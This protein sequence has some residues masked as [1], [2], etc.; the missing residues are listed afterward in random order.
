MF[1]VEIVK[2]RSRNFNFIIF[3]LNRD[4]SH[5]DGSRGAPDHFL[6]PIASVGRAVAIEFRLLIHF[7]FAM[8]GL[9]N[10]RDRHPPDSIRRCFKTRDWSRSITYPPKNVYKFVRLR[11][12]M[13]RCI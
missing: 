2:N 8:A 1:F 7:H 5:I 12:S 3:H 11:L 9:E 4:L 6:P 13:G 10:K